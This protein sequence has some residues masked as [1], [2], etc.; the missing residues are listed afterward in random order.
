MVPFTKV[1]L[2]MLYE[3]EQELLLLCLNEEYSEYVEDSR[4]G[5][6]CEATL[7]LLCRA[8]H[9]KTL[10]SFVE[11]REANLRSSTR[12]VPKTNQGYIL[13]NRVNFR[14]FLKKSEV[15]WDQGY[16]L[17]KKHRIKKSEVLQT[18]AQSLASSIFLATK[19][20]HGQVKLRFTSTSTPKLAKLKKKKSCF[21]SLRVIEPGRTNSSFDLWSNFV[22]QRKSWKVATFGCQCQELRSRVKFGRELVAKSKGSFF[23]C[24]TWFQTLKKCKTKPLFQ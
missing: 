19:G 7:A 12:G 9:Q 14:I 2:S 4:L 6:G 13:S 18:P 16:Q 24:F 17:A 22:R 10:T 21:T 23:F 11:V 5:C 15:K 20:C 1:S 8:F 3:V